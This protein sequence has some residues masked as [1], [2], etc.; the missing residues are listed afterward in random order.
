MSFRLAS[1][2]AI[3]RS[4]KQWHHKN[5]PPH[6]AEEFTDYKFYVLNAAGHGAGF[7]EDSLADSLSIVRK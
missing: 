5:E 1:N 4:P 6:P 3:L 7:G 2:S